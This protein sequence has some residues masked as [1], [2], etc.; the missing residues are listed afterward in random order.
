[1][2]EL[3]DMANLGLYNP[4]SCFA[5][6]KSYIRSNRDTVLRVMKAFVE[7]VKFYQDNKDFSL[8]VIAEFTQ[9]KDLEVLKP[10]YETVVRF[11]DKV[12]HV[13]MKGIDFI[14]KVIEVRDS[15]AKN[16]DASSVVDF[17]FMQELEK[18][19]FVSA[20]WRN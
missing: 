15:R 18:T 7:G 9:N 19:G 11:Q 1:M 12:P 6:T 17:S 2:N 16:F 4:A 5:S 14:L 3:I 13:N 20:V 8:K 10:S